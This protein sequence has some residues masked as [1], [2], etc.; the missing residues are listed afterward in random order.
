[1]LTLCSR[2]E[3]PTERGGDI[4]FVSGDEPDRVPWAELHADATANAAGLH[5]LGVVPGDHI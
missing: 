1:M 2:I 5:A 4:I 3:Q